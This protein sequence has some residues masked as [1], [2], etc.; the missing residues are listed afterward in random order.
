VS[1]YCTKLTFTPVGLALSYGN[2]S[3]N[4]VPTETFNWFYCFSDGSRLV[5]QVNGHLDKDHNTLLNPSHL[6]AEYI[7]TDGKTVLLSWKESDF[8][9]FEAGLDGHNPLIVA[10]ND[11]CLANSM[12][13]VN[14]ETRSRAQVTHWGLK[15]SG[16][17]FNQESWSMKL[18]STDSS[19]SEP[20]MS[21][22]WVISP[23]FPFFA[24]NLNMLL[25]KHP[26]AYCW[27]FFLC[28]P[29]CWFFPT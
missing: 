9:A 17:S 6:K 8:I 22:D 18:N 3:L 25:P 24:V 23:F 27:T 19:V 13:L 21:F 7:G 14:S 16:E 28:F 12:C 29:F 4:P 15:L 10:S 5:G 26:T 20:E 2:D 1:N 11:N